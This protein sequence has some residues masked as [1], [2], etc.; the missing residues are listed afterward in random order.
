MAVEIKQRALVSGSRAF[1]VGVHRDDK[2][3]RAVYEVGRRLEMN[4]SSV[5]Q[6]ILERLSSR[7]VV[8]K[9]VTTE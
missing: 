8:S 4:L 9:K 7:N 3:D 1:R 2:L 6:K 5:G